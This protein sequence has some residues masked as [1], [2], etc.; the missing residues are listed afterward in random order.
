MST[1]FQDKFAQYFVTLIMKTL[2]LQ[3]LNI[4]QLSNDVHNMYTLITG[5]L[6]YCKG[7]G[8]TD[9]ASKFVYDTFFWYEV[10]GVILSVANNLP[11]FLSSII[12]TLV[13]LFSWDLKSIGYIHGKL[14]KI[15]FDTTKNIN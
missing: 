4:F 5:Q 1:G 9:D 3:Y 6:D 13:N 14:L 11:D 15:I 8:L 10:Y 7:S 2:T 12:F